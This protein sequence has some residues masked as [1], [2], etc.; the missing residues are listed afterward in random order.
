[1][2]IRRAIFWICA[3]LLTAV[4]LYMSWFFIDRYV[5]P[6]VNPHQSY[7]VTFSTKYAK[8]LGI[9][10]KAAYQA[11]LTDLE[12]KTIRL[13]VY[14]DDISPSEGRFQFD[15]YDWMVIVAKQHHASVILV[16]GQRVPRWP[17]CHVPQWLKESS[18]DVVEIAETTMVERVVDRYKDHV[19]VRAWQVENEPYLSVFGECRKTDRTHMEQLIDLVHTLDPSRS[20]V[21]TDSG[22]LGKWYKARSKADTFGI[23]LY[24]TSHNPYFGYIRYVIPPSFYHIKHAATNL[25]AHPENQS[26]IISELQLEPWSPIDITQQDQATQ[27]KLMN[28]AV[29]NEAIGY[30]QHVPVEEVWLWG[31]EWWYWQYQER[32]FAEPWLAAKLL[33]SQQ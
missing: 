28:R 7:G 30:A 21:V 24:R 3:V 32:N 4:V 11:I 8:Q 20:V 19:A 9:D 13:P 18:D 23:S 31:V 14:W 1:M 17:E 15:E 25:L 5:L 10:W 2:A 27:M 33:F 29:F 22:E 6:P 16:V 26:W 12:V